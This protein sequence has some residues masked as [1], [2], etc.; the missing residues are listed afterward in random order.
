MTKKKVVVKVSNMNVTNRKYLLFPNFRRQD[1]RLKALQIAAAVPGFQSLSMKGADRDV[2][3]VT[4]DGVDAVDLVNKLR[5]SVG[6]AKLETV[7]DVKEEK[8]E[9]KPKEREPLPPPP[10]P[11]PLYIVTEPEPPCCTIM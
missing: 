9:E 7:D 10:P 4:G 8:K 3:E 2:I 11:P 6:H 5:K 1:N